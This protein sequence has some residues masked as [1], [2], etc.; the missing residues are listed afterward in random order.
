MQKRIVFL[1]YPDFQLLDAAGPIAAFEIAE[2]HQPGTYSLRVAC[3]NPGQ[4][5]SS[6]GVSVLATGFGHARRLDTLVV[7]GGE[8]SR[9]A[10]Q[11]AVTRRFIAACAKQARRTVSVC[12]GAY[13]LAAAGL[14]N[15][16]RATTHWSRSVDFKRKFPLVDLDSDRIY[17]KQGHLWTSA[18]I[19][20]GVDLALALIEEDLGERIARQTAQHLVVDH[21]RPGGQSQFSALLEMDAAG[22]R[23]AQLLEHARGNLAADYSVAKLAEI[24]CMS[25][26]HFSRTFHAQTGMSPAKA[27]E[28]LRAEAAQVAL[29]RPGRSLESI[30]R[31]C[32]FG[33]A[34]RMRRAFVRLFGISPFSIRQKRH[35]R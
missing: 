20:A 11:C 34:D 31:A 17:V 12:S 5:R 29:A 25:P 26:R 3:V 30:S 8:G 6:S 1:I 23:F 14:L 32:G 21:R 7:V 4:V 16:K 13:L 33:S 9:A 2:R 15:G 27:V 19:S 18:G 10:M 28:R 24:A 22:G 35:H